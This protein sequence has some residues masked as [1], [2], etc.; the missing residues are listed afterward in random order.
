MITTDPSVIF[1]KIWAVK[2]KI[3]RRLEAVYGRYTV[4]HVSRREPVYGLY[5][6][7]E[8]ERQII[9][10][11]A[12]YRKRY[13]TVGIVLKSLLFQTV[14]ADRII[15]WLDADIP[16][17]KIT[18]EMK[19]FSGYGVE[20]RHTSDELKAHKKYYYAMKEFPDEYIITVD[21]DVVYPD[22]LIE[23]LWKAHLQNPGCICARRIHK[24]TFYRSGK[25][26][27]YL[28]WLWEFQSRVPSCL[29]CAT[30]GSG[31]LYPPHSLHETVFD[32]E[33]LKSCC[34]DADDLWLK[35]A[36]LKKGTRVAWA[37]NHLILPE[38][39]PFSQGEALY[40]SNMAGGN[41]A[42][43]DRLRSQFPE[44]FELLENSEKRRREYGT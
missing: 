44:V 17:N 33:R 4:R 36:G 21:D 20:Y 43:L 12:S 6:G 40:F 25:L 27:P 35:I 31:I 32:M 30:G 14:K 10:S 18:E 22:T 9:V 7:P 5:S 34:L 2:G 29:Y 24:M 37:K 42:A 1:R 28:D 39:A 13:G 41:D 26:R 11:L 15:V 23:S 19:A 8:R 16:E 3:R 38:S